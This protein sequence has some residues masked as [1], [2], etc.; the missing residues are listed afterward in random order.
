MS[1]ELTFHHVQLK[2]R[3]T[4]GA[5]DRDRLQRLLDLELQYLDPPVSLQRYRDS[6]IESQLFLRP[7]QSWHQEKE[8]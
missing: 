6:L 3:Q 1:R 4:V 7:S 2:L 5:H 8:Q